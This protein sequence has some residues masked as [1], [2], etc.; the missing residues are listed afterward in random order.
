MHRIM[1]GFFTFHITNVVVQYQRLGFVVD[2]YARDQFM[3][4]GQGLIFSSLI[5]HNW[6]SYL[7]SFDKKLAR[8]KG[9]GKIIT[10]WFSF[11]K[12]SRKSQNYSRWESRIHLMVRL[13]NWSK[14]CWNCW[15]CCSWQEWAW[16]L[17]EPIISTLKWA[18]SLSLVMVNL[19]FTREVGIS[20]LVKV[21]MLGW[22]EDVSK[23]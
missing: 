7:L 14:W 21:L 17:P 8:K 1:A 4:N 9:F 12:H 2:G 16:C 19:P 20:K 10:H 5:N 22:Q 13:Q 6:Q 18:Q 3:I 11:S 23:V 15:S